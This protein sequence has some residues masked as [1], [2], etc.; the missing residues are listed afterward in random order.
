M[1]S[2]GD[3]TYQRAVLEIDNPPNVQ[4]NLITKYESH[5]LLHL[6]HIFPSDVWALMIPFNYIQGCGKDFQSYIAI[7]NVFLS[8]VPTLSFL[9][10][11][12][13]S[14]RNCHMR[15]IYTRTVVSEVEFV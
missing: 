10:S 9:E 5:G 12:S 7:L 4:P 11:V 6:T 15:M 3:T 13:Y 8:S 1:K 14:S 2:N